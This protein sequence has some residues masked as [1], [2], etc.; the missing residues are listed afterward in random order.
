MSE[1]NVPKP[2]PINIYKD[3]VNRYTP[4][5]TKSVDISVKDGPVDFV[6]NIHYKSHFKK[7]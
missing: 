5:R 6:K 4:F 1:L 2:D 3:D 7:D